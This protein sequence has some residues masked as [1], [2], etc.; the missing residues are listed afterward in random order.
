MIIDPE[1]PFAQFRVPAQVRIWCRLIV[2]VPRMK[3]R[4]AASKT[5]FNRLMLGSRPNF[6]PKDQ[7]IREGNVK[8]GAVDTL[9]SR[10]SQGLTRSIRSAHSRLLH[11]C[12]LGRRDEQKALAAGKCGR[13]GADF[14]AALCAMVAKPAQPR[15][16][17]C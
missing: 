6:I 10:L 7:I 14:N 2:A 11:L 1:C 12:K 9:A 16:S 8:G 15:Q 4:L 17:V 13:P 3:C 5:A